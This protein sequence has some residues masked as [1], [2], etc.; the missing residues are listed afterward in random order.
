MDFSVDWFG[1]ETLT[2]SVDDHNSLQKNNPNQ[3]DQ[4]RPVT[5]STSQQQA[6]RNGKRPK[7]YPPVRNA[8]IGKRKQQNPK[9]C[10]NCVIDWITKRKNNGEQEDDVIEAVGNLHVSNSLPREYY[11][12]VHNCKTQKADEAFKELLKNRYNKARHRETKKDIPGPPS[13][14]ESDSG[15]SSHAQEAPNDP[16]TPQDTHEIARDYLLK[17]YGKDFISSL[18]ILTSLESVR[19]ATVIQDKEASQHLATYLVNK[20]PAAG[21]GL[22]LFQKAHYQLKADVQDNYAEGFSNPR[23]FFNEQVKLTQAVFE[24]TT[25]TMDKNPTLKH[26]SIIVE[27]TFVLKFK[28]NEEIMEEVVRQIEEEGGRLYKIQLERSSNEV[29]VTS[30]NFKNDWIRQPGC[31]IIPFAIHCSEINGEHATMENQAHKDIIRS[32]DLSQLLEEWKWVV[33]KKNLCKLEQRA[34]EMVAH[35]Y[36]GRNAAQSIEPSD[37]DLRKESKASKESAINSNES[38]P[39]LTKV[40]ESEKQKEPEPQYLSLDPLPEKSGFEPETEEATNLILEPVA[41]PRS[42]RRHVET[43][44]APRSK[45]RHVCWIRSYKHVCME[46]RMMRGRMMEQELEQEFKSKHLVEALADYFYADSHNHIAECYQASSDV[47]K[48]AKRLRDRVHKWYSNHKFQAQK[49]GQKT[50]DSETLDSGC[51]TVNV[52]G[53]FK[54]SCLS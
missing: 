30:V 22:S 29:K 8:Q 6:E 35:A 26:G 46:G 19:L 52:E 33:Y 36:T 31:F 39:E 9:V 3:A 53:D 47:K 12:R 44:A 11:H 4:S 54:K 48:G 41:A 24:S 34:E 10:W 1:V 50:L 2:D 49:S 13:P 38:Q 51:S 5:T 16:I 7:G 23:L 45:R 28:A 20:K 40:P 17:H 21:L 43:V 42:K 37:M 25:G 32:I 15:T 14:E 18:D 27:S